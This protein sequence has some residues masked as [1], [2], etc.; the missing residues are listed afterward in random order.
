MS[1][2]FQPLTSIQKSKNKR[3]VLPKTSLIQVFLDTDSAN[4]SDRS[5]SKIL[6]KFTN[7]QLINQF[8]LSKINSTNPTN[9]ATTNKTTSNWTTSETKITPAK[10]IEKLQTSPNSHL[11]A[12][13]NSNKKLPVNTIKEKK[14]KEL[15]RLCIN[16]HSEFEDNNQTDN[17]NSIS[18][19]INQCLTSSSNIQLKNNKQNLI[20]FLA[21]D[22]FLDC[23]QRLDLN[24]FRSLLGI[25]GDFKGQSNN[26]EQPDN[27]KQLLNSI[28]DLIKNDKNLCNKFS[29]FLTCENALG[30]NLLEQSIQYEKCYEFFHKLDLLIPNKC[31]FKKLLQSTIIANSDLLLTETD[32][33]SAKIEEIKSRIR[34]ITKN[35]PLINLE[36]DYLFDQR[37]VN[38]EPVYEKVSLASNG[39]DWMEKLD[40][41]GYKA[42]ASMFMNV[43]HIDLT[44]VSSVASSG[45]SKV[46]VNIAAKF[47]KF[48]PMTVIK[49]SKK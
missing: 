38:L 36:L 21:R 49:C 46:K 23:K 35:N 2:N 15:T 5:R 4:N 13:S 48:K 12:A 28:Y 9:E 45:A 26:S 30:Y 19:N 14:F 42:E 29:A 37:F 33:F 43:E 17:T 25:L 39:L 8:N 6:P 31:S 22:F 41:I 10:L 3:T 1:V 40:S 34:T 27:Q 20:N 32:T 24:S 44:Q 7:Q 16:D 11:N 18:L 47:I